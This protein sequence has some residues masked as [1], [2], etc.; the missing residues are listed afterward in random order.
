[1]PQPVE[2]KKLTELDKINDYDEDYLSSFNNLK[3]ELNKILSPKM[4]NNKYL[5]GKELSEYLK[6]IV[7]A[8]NDEKD[9]YMYDAFNK[10]EANEATKTQKSYENIKLKI[11]EFNEKIASDLWESKVEP[12]IKPNN[13]EFYDVIE[14]DRDLDEIKN[15]L[16][17]KSFELEGDA[18]EKFWQN[19]LDNKNYNSYKEKIQTH[20]T[21]KIRIS[22][23][24]ITQMVD[25]F[26][27]DQ[28]VVF[29]IIQQE[30]KNI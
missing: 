4:V 17:A 12:N 29:I 30:I 20:T 2:P 18:F 24:L 21:K 9:F 11:K 7:Q 16:K 22:T 5:I 1:M 23:N 10:I 14:F 8:I 28:E 27:Q 3:S 15:D 25:H 13:I 26:I 6:I 19:F